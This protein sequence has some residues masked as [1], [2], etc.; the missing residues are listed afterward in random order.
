MPSLSFVFLKSFF[1]DA[2]MS[3]NESRKSRV[4]K[5]FSFYQLRIFDELKEKGKRL[6]E[7]RLN[8]RSDS[9]SRKLPILE[10]LLN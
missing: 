3:F 2:T 4:P 5:L 7:I 1:T 9:D 6:F 10:N 8:K